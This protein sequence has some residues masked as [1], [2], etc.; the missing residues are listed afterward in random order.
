MLTVDAKRTEQILN[1][2]YMYIYSLQKYIDIL[3]ILSLSRINKKI[4]LL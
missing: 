4:A 3:F 1:N 2:V